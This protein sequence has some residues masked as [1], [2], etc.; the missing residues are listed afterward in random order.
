MFLMTGDSKYIDLLERTIFNGVLSGISLGG[1]EYFYPNPLESD[2]VKKFNMGSCTR[3][4]WFDCSCC[5][6]N[7]TRFMPSLPGY[8]YAT[9]DKQ[10]F[11]NLFVENKANMN[12]DGNMVSINQTTEYP[13]K[14]DV[15]IEVNPEKP[16]SFDLMVRIPGWAGDKVMESDLY[17]YLNPSKDKVI[18]KVN[19]KPIPLKTENGYAVLS[20]SWN[21]GD[22]VELSL[23]MEIKLVAAN[24]K[25]ADDKGKIA[26]ERGPIVYCAEE[27]DNNSNLF[28]AKFS[29]TAKLEAEYNKDLLGGVMVLS[30]KDFI[31]SDNSK[32]KQITL[33]PYFSWNNRGA[34]KM[35]VWFPVI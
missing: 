16:G 24:E 2:G 10:L 25:V 27:T 3:S 1:N 19:G 34:G 8:V 35:R 30:T 32:P 7:V 33:V 4:A 13:W 20:R 5:P 31:M 14:G 17:H 21:K 23:P 26:V 18:L 6:S 28:S 11:I 9:K 15:K 12:V 22:V 29:K